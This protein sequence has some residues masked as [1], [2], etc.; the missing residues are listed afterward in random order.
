MANAIVTAAKEHNISLIKPADFSSIAGKG[1]Q[2]IINNKKIALGNIRLLELFNLKPGSFSS[3]AEEL[4]REGA[5]VMF[6]VVG[7]AF[8]YNILCIPI[9]AGIL[10]P[11][12]G[13]LLSR[14]IGAFAMSLSS[15]S[16]ITNALRLKRVKF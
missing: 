4:Q 12:T 2:G 7:G 3:Q 16:V 8:A 9:A 1:V 14:M 5:T 10:Y 13:L 6:V 15:V 11:W